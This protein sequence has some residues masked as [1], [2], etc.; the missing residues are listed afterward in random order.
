LEL[1]ELIKP[2]AAHTA[3]GRFT[4]GG[5]DGDLQYRIDLKRLVAN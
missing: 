5:W 4:P 3:S 2:L 1:T